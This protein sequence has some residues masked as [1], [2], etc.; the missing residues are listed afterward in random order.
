MRDGIKRVLKAMKEDVQVALERD[1]AA[2]GPLEVALT[3]PGLHAVWAHRAAHG[4][5]NQGWRFPARLVQNATRFFTGVD[6]HPAASLGRR[7]FID[8]AEGVVI[9][10]TAEVGD[11]VLI[12][13]QVTLGGT[14]ADRGKRHP[15]VGDRA[16]LG[17]GAKILG[18]ITVGDDAQ[19]GAN[20]VVLHDIPD[21]AV[22]VGVPTRLVRPGEAPSNT[23]TNPAPSKQN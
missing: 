2:T 7:L 17:A 1:P 9:G 10:E 18:P 12:Y 21:S 5:W 14:S 15:T 16:V 6:I 13:H 3:Y 4:L 20:A 23:R 19:V 8:H 22:A 11:D